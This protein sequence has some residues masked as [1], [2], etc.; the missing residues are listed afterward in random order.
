M[1]IFNQSIPS[2]LP[3]VGTSIFTVMSKLAADHQAI[4]LSQG[5]PDFNIS[6]ELV[7]LVNKY[8]TT[9]MNQY[10]PMQGL[11][12]LREVISAKFKKLYHTEYNPDTEITVTAGGTQALYSTISALVREG[13]EVVVFT[14]AYD[15]YEPAVTLHKGITRYVKLSAPD[16]KINWKEVKKTV[17]G[18]TRMIILNSPH[19]PSGAVLS[20]NDI[21]EL[22][23]I[24]KGTGIIILSD[25]VYEHLIFDGQK[26][27]SM[28]TSPE[29][30]SRSVIV[31]SFG[32]IF[33]VT[34]WKMGYMAGPADL[35]AEVR[36]AHQY[37]VFC[38]NTPAQHAIAEYLKDENNYL[39]LNNFYQAKRDYFIEGIK[40]SRFKIVPAKG[41]YFQL[42]DYSPISKENDVDFAKRLTTEY[43]L[44]SIPVSVF[45][46]TKTDQHLLRFCFA[47]KEDT[48]DKAIQILNKI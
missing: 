2:K 28:A 7:S 43:K 27:L 45:Y 13:D 41:T 16:F 21:K 11:P 40:N 34:G 10:A 15:S 17:N 4:N 35:M 14:P 39:E 24:V 22:E 44:A 48:L 29:L 5:F 46:N 12:V 8:M 33:H 26:H 20:S 31:A 32:K 36:K 9:G 38:C 37:Q 23:K 1:P 30:A 3:Q 47:K 19:N 18:K 6:S 25:E 42:L